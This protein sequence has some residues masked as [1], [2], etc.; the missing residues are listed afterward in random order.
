MISWKGLTGF[1]YQTIEVGEKARQQRYR[2]RERERQS[3]RQNIAG[4]EG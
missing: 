1:L 2:K 4:R 3:E